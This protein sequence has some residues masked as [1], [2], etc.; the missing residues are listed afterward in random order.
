MPYVVSL[1]IN[2]GETISNFGVNAGPSASGRIYKRAYNA[3]KN[4]A[5]A[6]INIRS[7]E[8]CLSLHVTIIRNFPKS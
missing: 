3:T 1:P 4:G 7:A 6:E 5:M 8:A 2:R